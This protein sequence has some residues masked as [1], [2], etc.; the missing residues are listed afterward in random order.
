[1]SAEVTITPEIIQK[2][3]V[4]PEEYQEIRS[5]L[6]R[7]P[8]IT[9]LGIFS[10]MWSEHCSYKN[11]KK[12]L[13]LLPKDGPRMLVKAGEEN[14]GVVDIGDGW[15]IA[16]KIES[17]N[18]PSA[19][20][21]FQGAATGVG[22]ILR[23]IFTMGARPIAS[24]NSLRFGTL[25][26]PVVRR[27]LTGVVAGIAHYGNCIGVPTIGGE[28]YFDESYEGN[29]LVNAFALGLARKEDIVKAKAEGAGNPVFYLG[30]ATGRDG[31][32]GASFASK[33]LTEES[34]K[35][36]P[37]V[38][39]GDPFLEKLLL[40]AVLELLKTGCVVGIQDMGA[41]GLTCSTCETASRGDTGIEIDVAKVPQRETGM[42]PYEVMLSESQ[43]RMLVILKKG[44]EAEAKRI[45]EKWDLHAEEIGQVTDDKIMRV[46]WNGKVAAEIPPRRLA[47]DAP[48]YDRKAV[49]PK[50]L[51]ET[52]AY[53]WR[54]AGKPGDLNAALLKLLDSP[55]IASKEWVYRQYDHMVR[56]NTTVLPGSDAS[57]IRIKGTNKSIAMSVDCNS[58]YCYLDPYEGGKIAVLESARNVACSGAKPLSITNCLNFGNPHNPEIFWQLQ[59]C[60]EG[61]R[62]ACLALGTPVSGG[63]VSLYN[64]NPKGAIDPTPTVGMVGLI[65]GRQ[66]VTSHFKDAGD[67][68]LLL[69]TTREEMGGSEYLK[70]LF[71][72]KS[73]LPPRADLAE[74][75][76]LVDLLQALA[77][78]GLLKSAHDC[79]EGGL[80]VALAESCIS[81]LG[82]ETGAQLTVDAAG[83]AP[84]VLL[85]SETQSRAVI[86]VA[87]ERLEEARRLIA[88]QGYPC[89]VIGKVGGHELVINGLVRVPVEVLSHTWRGSIAR[90]MDAAGGSSAL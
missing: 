77:A 83:L 14:A 45:F 18:H 47:D 81:S 86:T 44:R 65:E 80:A 32:G 74:A 26:Q 21:P 89:A 66:P 36:R 23:D 40:E 11:S 7:D 37:A 43:E 69:G 59:K 52:R 31:M 3:N 38:Q 42:V 4:T 12:V 5:I 25:D 2:H 20:E 35:D 27:L 29:P 76:K 82:Q 10:V 67:A 34:E 73:G 90:R 19:I 56:T 55:T 9:E 57:V 84:E 85:F 30:A 88:A 78:K 15:V 64:Q 62:D 75:V 8:N 49:E 72:V 6:G 51:T 24:M 71:K 33:D 16:F 70:T 53:D 60:V 17:H 13:K 61:M 63:N 50:Y 68:V 87:P 46:R 58:T 79:A 39:V 28:V 22:G 54:S 1:M 48:V 41:A